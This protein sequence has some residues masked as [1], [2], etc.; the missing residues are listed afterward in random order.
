MEW[1]SSKEFDNEYGASRRW[2]SDSDD[3]VAGNFLTAVEP[4]ESAEETEEATIEDELCLVPADERPMCFAFY[5]VNCLKTITVTRKTNGCFVEQMHVKISG[6]GY[7][8]I[9][10]NNGDIK[11]HVECFTES[12]AAELGLVAKVKVEEDS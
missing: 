12:T 6:C 9:I 4:V 8:N 2:F 3:W 10:T 5:V 11:V 1:H 7:E